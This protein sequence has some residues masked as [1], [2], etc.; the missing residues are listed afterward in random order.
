MPSSFFRFLASDGETTWSESSR[1]LRVEDLCSNLCWL[2]ACSRMSFPVPV[3]RTRLAVPLWVF[4]FGMSSVLFVLVMSV[5]HGSTG[6]PHGT[7]RLGGAV[8]RVRPEPDR[9]GAGRLLLGCRLLGRGLRGRRPV[10]RAL[11]RL[12]GRPFGRGLPAFCLRRLL[13]LLGLHLRV[14]VRSDHH[15][16]VPAVLLRVGLDDAE[17]GDVGG[18]P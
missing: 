8:L 12:L 16:H 5:P 17:L 10:G 13:G 6:L 9:S 4:C 3:T 2:F 1:R 15:D 11:G 7:V 18:Q 14:A